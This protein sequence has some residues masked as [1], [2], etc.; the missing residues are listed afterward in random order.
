MVSTLSLRDSQSLTHRSLSLSLSLCSSIRATLTSLAPTTHPRTATRDAE[1]TITLSARAEWWAKV[2]PLKWDAPNWYTYY[3]PYSRYVLMSRVIH[4]PI[5]P[6][7]KRHW[8]ACRVFFITKR[9]DRGTID[10]R[11][12]SKCQ[13]TRALTLH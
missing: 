7:V 8:C 2:L 5:A 10:G 6:C 1:A 11:A 13:R 4:K 9:I 3:S 12:N